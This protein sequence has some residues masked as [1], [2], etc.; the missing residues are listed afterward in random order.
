MR[1]RYTA[2]V[3]SNAAHIMATTHPESPH[4]NPES[5][6]WER[7]IEAFCRETVFEKLEVRAARVDGDRGWVEFVAF[8]RQEG[9]GVS[10][11]EHSEFQCVDGRWLYLYALD[12]P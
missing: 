4:F 6:A 12:S 7:E 1:S 3:T 10:M 11:I 9:Q 2:Y 8:L 5:E